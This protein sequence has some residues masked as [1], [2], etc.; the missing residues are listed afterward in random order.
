MTTSHRAQVDTWYRDHGDCAYGLAVR[1]TG[2]T[3]DGADALQSAFADIIGNGLCPR[4]GASE[5]AWLLGVVYNH[6]RVFRRGAGRRRRREQVVATRGVVQEMTAGEIVEQEETR[7]LVRTCLAQLSERDRAVLHMHYLDGLTQREIAEAMNTKQGTV[8]SWISRGSKRLEKLMRKAGMPTALTVMLALRQLPALSMPASLQASI[9]S[10]I[11]TGLVS[12]VATAASGASLG[13]SLSAGS[14]GGGLLTWVGAKIA[15]GLCAL[16][17]LTSGVVASLPDAAPQHASDLR[18]WREVQ[19]IGDPSIQLYLRPIGAHD[20]RWVRWQRDDA[21]M[22][23]TVELRPEPASLHAR[24]PKSTLGLRLPN[25]LR[26]LQEGE[27]FLE[28]AINDPQD[29]AGGYLHCL[30]VPAAPQQDLMAALDWPDQAMGLM[31]LRVVLERQDEHWLVT[32]F[33][34]DDQRWQGQ[35]PASSDDALIYG[36]RPFTILRCELQPH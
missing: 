23:A 29:L 16:T 3:D 25:G 34:H 14:G 26:N 9:E 31:T 4:A 30:G 22:R 17:V 7:T 10:M 11:A 19:L 24:D 2:S 36:D 21:G 35:V 13:A 5:R 18:S 20:G 33:Q 15:A 27:L 6:C 12:G 8:G 28:L 1:V 32:I